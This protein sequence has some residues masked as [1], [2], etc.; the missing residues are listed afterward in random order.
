MKIEQWIIERG[1]HDKVRPKSTRLGQM[2]RLILGSKEKNHCSTKL[3]LL[4]SS[5]KKG[6]IM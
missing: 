4:L 1:S 3:S 6:I 5:I 2:E